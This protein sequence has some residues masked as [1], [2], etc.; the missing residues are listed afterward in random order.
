MILFKSYIFILIALI[1]SSCVI[2]DRSLDVISFNIRYD[3]PA[4][5]VNSWSNRK[6]IAINFLKEQ[7][8]DVIGMQE[9]LLQQLNDI[10]EELTSYSCISAGRNDGLESGE[11]VPILYKKDKY[12]LLASSHFWLSKTPDE[13]GS[14]S[15]G[16]VL[17][18]IV[19]WVKLK[20][21]SN[22]Y[23][24]F[25]FNTHFSHVSKYARNESAVLLLEKIKN[26]AGDAPV[27]VTGDF[28][29]D[30]GE[31]MYKTMIG[32]WIDHSPLWDARSES[33]TSIVGDLSTFNGF[34][35]DISDVVI[36]HIFVNGQFLVHSFETYQIK[37]EEVFISDHYP[38][39]SVLHFRLNEKRK[40]D[41]EPKELIKTLP[42]PVF[43][44]SQI[45][46]DTQLL[47]PIN[48]P[49]NSA[50]IYYTL[51][52]SNPDTSSNRYNI[53]IE[54]KESTTI[55]AF[56]ASDKKYP[57]KTIQ[58]TFIKSGKHTFKIQNIIP[59]PSAPHAL[60]DYSIL[61]DKKPGNTDL[62]D[63]SW[64]GV[65]GVD[66]DIICEFKK[67]TKIKDVYI[68]L[69][70]QPSQWIIGPSAIEVMVSNDNIT[71]EAFSNI[72]LVPS[73]DVNS[74]ENLL[75]HLN[76]F[77][78]GKYVKIS[79]NNGGNLPPNHPSSGNPSWIFV[80]EIVIQ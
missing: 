80:D 47:V 25:V 1:L 21:I 54:L 74:N 72:S 5:G 75:I 31:R 4:D 26:L 10:K 17:P 29:A 12:E 62:K 46:F 61:C 28:N 69:L 9:V 58:K 57:S 52:G 73:S 6:G 18:R 40:S 27:V 45:V 78:K 11:M 19:T 63:G 50:S 13:P 48:L 7:S 43:E 35:N 37:K 24:F 33:L 68:S 55:T 3:N 14:K 15:W 79:L 16:A 71:F 41:V 77:K 30:P 32:H 34:R 49:G 20:D 42:D 67:A 22:G 51:D 44:T 36:D 53:P 56:A 65:Q 2:G 59:Q 38:I 39:K 60:N 23:I 66:I 76:G 64:L 70:S 8:P